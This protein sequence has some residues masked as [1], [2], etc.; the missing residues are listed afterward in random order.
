[1]EGYGVYQ[2]LNGLFDIALFP[3]WILVADV[4]IHQWS[5]GAS[6]FISATIYAHMC[7]YCLSCTKRSDDYPENN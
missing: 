6:L 2:S 1:M 7:L 5:N 3:S 4:C